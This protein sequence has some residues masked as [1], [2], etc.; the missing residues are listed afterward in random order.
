MTTTN[1]ERLTGH[2]VTEA[3]PSGTALAAH[4]TTGLF[5][6]LMTLSGLLYV[7]GVGKIMEQLLSLGY[8]IYF[9]K[10]L[11]VAKLLG[12]VGL[13]LPRRPTLREWAYAGFTFDLIAAVVS[14]IATGG[15]A[16][17]VPAAVALALLT[18]S[19]WLRHRAPVEAGEGR[20]ST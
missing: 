9:L 4:I 7:A 6:A 12:V 1:I 16:E 11:G 3:G 15:A 5:A 2:S 8:P 18:S 13:L 14:H 19:Y 17:A 10:L 20:I